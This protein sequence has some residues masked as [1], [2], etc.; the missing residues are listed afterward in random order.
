M[1]D[2]FHNETTTGQ[3]YCFCPRCEYMVPQYEIED[4][5]NMSL[6]A[7]VTISLL[8]VLFSAS[9]FFYIRERKYSVALT[10]ELY[11]FTRQALFWNFMANELMRD[12][13]DCEMDHLPIEKYIE[14][15]DTEVD[16]VFTGH[17]DNIVD[18][19]LREYMEFN[20]NLS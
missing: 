12:S 11:E 2:K 10:Q 4:Q 14:Y 20:G 7:I 8:L 6:L 5:D 9:V 19:A 1:S 15:A 18:E 17:P 3:L 16:K 13:V